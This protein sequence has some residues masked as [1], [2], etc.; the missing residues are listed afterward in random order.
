LAAGKLPPRGGSKNEK[1]TSTTS[2][3]RT[4]P[5]IWSS[6]R[7]QKMGSPKRLSFLENTSSWAFSGIPMG[8]GVTIPLP[9]IFFPH[10]F[11][12]RGGGDSASKGCRPPISSLPGRAPSPGTGPGRQPPSLTGKEWRIEPECFFSYGYLLWLVE[13]PGDLSLE[14]GQQRQSR[15]AVDPRRESRLQPLVI[16]P[17]FLSRTIEPFPKL[18]PI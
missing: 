18:L 2:P 10:P 9:A 15:L 8:L 11:K 3:S 13:N 7:G 6:L 1:T 4:S 16:P 17:L 14:C 5:R 12:R